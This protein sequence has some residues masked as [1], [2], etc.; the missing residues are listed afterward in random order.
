[1]DRKAGNTEFTVRLTKNGKSEEKTFPNIE[2]DD[3]VTIFE[4]DM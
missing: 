4:F 1:M 2:E 3:E